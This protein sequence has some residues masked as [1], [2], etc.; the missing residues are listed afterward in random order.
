MNSF[1]KVQQGECG[2]HI[3]P[4][5]WL[6]GESHEKIAAE[7]QKIRECGIREVCLESRTHPDFAGDGWWNDVSFILQEAR[8]QN[9]RVWILDDDHFPTGHAAG[10]FEDRAA[11][12][13]KTYIAEKH[14]DFMG[15]LEQAFLWRGLIPE[16]DA[17]I[18]AVLAVKRSDPDTTGLNPSLVLDLTDQAGEDFIFFTFPETGLFRVFVLYTTQQGPGRENYMNLI[19]TESV[20]TLIDSVYEP[21]F[22]HF[23]GYFGNTLAGFFSD[24]PELGNVNNFCFDD[25]LGNEGERYPW[26]EELAMA[27]RNRWGADM[28]INLTGLWYDLGEASDSS[29][30]PR[31]RIDYMDELT[32][33]VGCCFS[34]Q[35]GDWCRQH[36]VEYIGHVIEDSGSSL[37]MGCSVGHY[38]REM[39]GEDIAGIDVVHHQIIPGHTGIRTQW[40]AHDGDGEFFHYELA[41]LASSEAH[42]D[43]KKKGRA[44]CEIFGNFG[45][46]L[47]VPGMK[48]LLDHMLVRG[49]NYFVPHA[50]SV[51]DP[52][53]D[54]PPHFYAQGNNPQF[55][56]FKQLMQYTEKMCTLLD[57]GAPVLSAAVL[58]P[59]ESVWSGEETQSLSEVCRILMQHQ[60]DFDLIPEDFLTKGEYQTRGSRFGL[61]GNEY[62]ALIV[63]GGKILSGAALEFMQRYPD[64][65]VCILGETGQ[66]TAF[67][68]DHVR[69]IAAEKAPE[70]LPT[71][72]RQIDG[73]CLRILPDDG[74]DS[75]KNLRA[76][77]YQKEDELFCFLFNEDIYRTVRFRLA[78][79]AYAGAEAY[80]PLNDIRWVLPV[81]NNELRLSLRPGETLLL[82]FKQKPEAEVPADPAGISADGLRKCAE[83]QQEGRMR[84]QRALE[85]RRF[86]DVDCS[87]SVLRDDDFEEILKIPAGG[88]FPNMNRLPQL[89]EY[90]G[91]YRYQ[92]SFDM[93]EREGKRYFLILPGCGNGAQVL[94]N[95]KAVGFILSDAGEA[96]LTAELIS[97]TNRLEIRMANTLIWQRKDP[98]SAFGQIRPTGLP[99]APILVIR[100]ERQMTD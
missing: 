30:S 10:A 45:W 91:V 3:L 28:R 71:L 18:L 56:Y 33:L 37:Y 74:T 23:S 44:L 61:T 12:L 38:F 42:I 5:L 75:L 76:L 52:N 17:K 16:D 9:M 98:I 41:K 89:R 54:C 36:G 82:S 32:R 2:S 100:S 39:R 80:D 31:L 6:A 19:D 25:C 59:A 67:I 68:P 11:H 78:A 83:I 58:Y 70:T 66:D 4:F 72:L 35:L 22:Q 97:G 47:D 24:E 62:G 93:T 79:E 50:F 85:Q 64:I 92:L 20:R 81:R 40:K 88:S 51:T 94:L 73:A 43:P 7:M 87:V 95:G 63:P 53:P 49:I 90:C 84:T 8:K 1:D 96:E 29:I 15:G 65:P 55:A 46:G 57:G 86:L 26:S 27:L 69:V 21:H 14:A 34:G 99:G 77:R 13:K 48:W 60:L